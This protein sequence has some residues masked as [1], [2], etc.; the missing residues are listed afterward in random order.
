MSEGGVRVV[1]CLGRLG[2]ATQQ[3]LAHP[4]R[5]TTHLT[6]TAPPLHSRTD[7]P[8]SVTDT[9]LTH[10][11]LLR[12]VQL[13]L[14]LCT[15]SDTTIQ[16]LVI[17]IRNSL[18]RK[19]NGNRG[20]KYW[21]RGHKDVG[22]AWRWDTGSSEESK[23]SFNPS[24]VV[25]EQQ[26]PRIWPCCRQWPVVAECGEQEEWV[27]SFPC[28]SPSSSCPC[29][30]PGPS[31]QA[32]PPHRRT[33]TPPRATW[34]RTTSRGSPPASRSPSSPPAKDRDTRGGPRRRLLRP[35]PPPSPPPRPRGPGLPSIV[36]FGR[37]K[38]RGS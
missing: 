3:S 38:L 7:Q 15:V 14:T 30:A 23:S 33:I 32:S 4:G 16:S 13:A 36:E 17:S 19:G 24:G 34:P 1:S 21:L 6:R 29:P 37:R 35:P 10:R 11:R 20:E 31:A 26:R 8:N 9:P 22:S 12:P 2:P 18:G 25:Q 28:T 27:P 5:A